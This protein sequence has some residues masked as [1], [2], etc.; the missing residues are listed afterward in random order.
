M[1]SRLIRE[2]G[3]QNGA[4]G[5]GL[6]PTWPAMFFPMLIPLD[7]CL[8]SQEFTV[9][10]VRRGPDIGSEHYPLIVELGLLGRKKRHII[11][12]KSRQ[13]HDLVLQG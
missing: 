4:R 2:T 8:A 12:P 11:K 6:A 10:E 5:R 1:F 7:Y 3:L 9:A 13:S